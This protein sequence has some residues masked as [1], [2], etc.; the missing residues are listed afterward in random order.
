MKIHFFKAMLLLAITALI[1]SINPLF[2]ILHCHRANHKITENFEQLFT[3]QSKFW[4]VQSQQQNPD[5]MTNPI[6]NELFKETKPKMDRD[7]AQL[8][9]TFKEDFEF[10]KKQ[11]E[12]LEGLLNN[13]F[14]ASFPYAL[15]VCEPETIAKQLEKAGQWKDA[16][17]ALA[18]FF[19]RKMTSE[20]YGYDLQATFVEVIAA[21]S[22]L[23]Q[24]YKGVLDD[25]VLEAIPGNLESQR[26]A[27][28]HLNRQIFNNANSLA[29]FLTKG[30]GCK[31]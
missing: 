30:F 15:S 6:L 31:N 10:N 28:R 19:A 25:P 11:M 12:K 24:A 3:S 1:I 18:E 16:T 17:N 26:E 29:D 5:P 27:A 7:I 22:Q 9:E 20:Q 14:E 13:F 2:A 21:Q 4:A 8:L 23:I